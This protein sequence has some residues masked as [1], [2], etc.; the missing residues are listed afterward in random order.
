MHIIFLN[1]Y[2]NY[3]L[4][5]KILQNWKREEKTQMEKINMQIMER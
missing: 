3:K 1:T 4:E 2:K 5:G